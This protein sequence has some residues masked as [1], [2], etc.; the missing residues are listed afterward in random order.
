MEN[1]FDP[2]LTE[3]TDDDIS[4]ETADFSAEKNCITQ[5][6]LNSIV[7]R[8]TGRAIEKTLRE[9][10]FSG[11]GKGREQLR[12]FREQISAREEEF[13]YLS[14]KLS[15]AEAV[16]AEKDNEILQLREMLSDEQ[17]TRMLLI[18]GVGEK[19]IPKALSL[20]KGLGGGG[21]DLSTAVAEIVEKYPHFLSE[22]REIPRFSAPTGGDG[23]SAV[24]AIFSKR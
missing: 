7:A 16:F 12:L 3:E 9:L 18:S 14:E 24:K 6:Q 5:E 22:K 10:G 20:V 21:M 4:S 17:T 11:T 13:L 23:F 2:I 1:E 19:N 15:Q 8:E